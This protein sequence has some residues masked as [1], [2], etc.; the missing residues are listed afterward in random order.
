MESIKEV[1]KLIDST[2]KDDAVNSI[3]SWNIIKDWFNSEI[4]DIR[5]IINNAKDWLVNYQ[6]SLIEKT[7]IQKLKIKHTNIFGYFIEIPLNQNE[8][9]PDDFVHRQTL[10]WAA[11]YITSELKDFER[12]V[13]EW[14]WILV[15]K[16]YEL[17]WELRND[18]LKKFKDLKKSSSLTWKIDMLASFSSVSSNNNYTKPE[19]H[20]WLELKI[21]SGRH[22]IIESLESDFISNDLELDKKTHFHILTWPNMWWKSTFL[23]QN[24]LIILMAHIWIYVPAK[25]S[26]I[27]LTDKIFSR[28]WAS[29]NLFLWQSTFM[30]EM[31]EM[32]NILH[33]YTDRSFII[34]DEIWRWTST[35]D[36]MSIAWAVLKFLH[37]NKKVKTLFATH[38][39]E[40]VEES[41]SL[42]WVKNYSVAIWENEDWIIFLRKIIKGWIKKSYGLE[43]A[44]LW[45]IGDNVLLEARKMLKKLESANLHKWPEQLWFWIIPEKEI[46][47]IEVKKESEIE[48]I[49]KKLD[50]NSLTPLD[51]L[52]LLNELKRKL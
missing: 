22:P 12:K 3:T 19:V 37:D 30:V 7:W 5:N 25:D 26:K 39:H 13:V 1:I 42:P 8:N 46:E 34:I 24:A 32:A 41:I 49:I 2:L 48:E 18:I 50:L 51:W 40:L 10:V 9:I 14:E 17:F 43:V 38:Y 15:Q 4:D 27:P 16:E 31:Q 23:R 45:W 29:D 52:N 36:W 6:N 11:R 21:K 28:V 44:K 33:N 47:Y 35:Y 20:N